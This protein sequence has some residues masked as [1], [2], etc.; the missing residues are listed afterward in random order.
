MAT[1]RQIK[2]QKKGYAFQVDIRVKGY[3]RL[4]KTF[5]DLDAKTAKK[6]A[7]KWASDTELEMLNGTFRESDNPHSKSIETVEDMILYF[8]DNIAASRYS[9]PEKY[10]I[11]YL[12]WISKIGNIKLVDLT[13][14]ILASCKLVLMQEK[15]IKKGKEITRSNNTINKYLMC[16]SAVLTYATNELELI[17]VNP[18]SKVGTLTKPNSRARFLSDE[19]IDALEN[20]CLKKGIRLFIFFKLLLKTGGRFNEARHLQVKDIDYKNSKVYYLDTKNNTHR[21]V[22]VSSDLLET[23]A[24]YLKDNNITESYIFKSNSRGAKLADMKGVLEQAIK[25]AGIKK[26]RIHD[27]RHTTASILAKEGFSLLE[28]AEILGQKSLTVT[29]NYSHLTV[30]HLEKRLASVMDRY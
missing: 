13:A 8:K 26:F 7:L 21:G 15:I 12:W 16:L 17:P 29:R 5:K 6:K 11:M 3:K 25:E 23:I 27:I 28:I 10:T 20:A 30:K 18:M 19:E 14:S 1:I 2:T 22:H 9:D 24:E 4:T